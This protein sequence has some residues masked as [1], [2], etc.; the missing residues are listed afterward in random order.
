MSIRQITVLSILIISIAVIFGLNYVE[1]ELPTVMI[2]LAVVAVMGSG[3]LTADV[4]K[5]KRMQKN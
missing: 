2:L 1:K 4:I 5:N 3:W